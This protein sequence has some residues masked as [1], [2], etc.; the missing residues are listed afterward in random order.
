MDIVGFQLRLLCA[1][2]ICAVRLFLP[3]LGKAK[4][5]EDHPE[6]LVSLNNLAF[7]FKAQG[8][9]AKAEPLYREALKK[10]PG[11]QLEG[12]ERDFGQCIWS[13]FR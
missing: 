9:L 2:A 6:T 3:R 1:D 11:A 8:Q 13:Q 12:F 7:L 10:S 5:G 4:L